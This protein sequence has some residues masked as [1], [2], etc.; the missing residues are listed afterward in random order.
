MIE[1]L[2]SITTGKS[3]S[4]K[5]RIGPYYVGEYDI[6]GFRF[7]RRHPVGD[8]MFSSKFIEQESKTDVCISIYLKPGTLL[9]Y[10]LIIALMSIVLFEYKI[11]FDLLKALTI[12][13]IFLIPILLAYISY[14]LDVKKAKSFLMELFQIKESSFLGN[15]K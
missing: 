13:I 5:K 2:E 9:G 4:G 7:K 15:H 14:R 1:K 10:I 8:C 3:L 6:S 11:D 12:I